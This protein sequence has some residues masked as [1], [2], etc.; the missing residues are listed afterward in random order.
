MFTQPFGLKELDSGIYS[1]PDAVIVRFVH[2]YDSFVMNGV[3]I[4]SKNLII[5]PP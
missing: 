2:L 1:A 4:L 3:M 5:T